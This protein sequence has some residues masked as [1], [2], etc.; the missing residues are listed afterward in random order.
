MA[1]AADDPGDASAGHGSFCT[2]AYL[3]MQRGACWLALGKPSRAITVLEGSVHSLPPAY[4]RDCGVA[5][6][7]Q[8][9]ALAA[10]GKPAQAATA[11]LRALDIARASGSGRV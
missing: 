4:R 1:A 2:P 7:R 8:A 5:L 3:E 11:A 10:T 6:S 9:A